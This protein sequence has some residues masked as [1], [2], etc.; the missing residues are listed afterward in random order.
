M[1]VVEWDHDIVRKEIGICIDDKEGERREKGRKEK[2]GSNRYVLRGYW[3]EK[4]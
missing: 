3:I 2:R 4:T 1:F